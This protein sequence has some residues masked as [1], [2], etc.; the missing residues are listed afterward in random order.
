MAMSA[1]RAGAESPSANSANNSLLA[2]ELR[3]K[4]AAAEAG[5]T[6]TGMSL[7]QAQ[8]DIALRDQKLG[9]LQSDVA[10]LKA[11]IVKQNRTFSTLDAVQEKLWDGSPLT[12]RRPSSPQ[13]G[14]GTRRSGGMAT[15]AWPRLARL[16]RASPAGHQP[17]RGS[18]CC[19]Q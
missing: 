19:R 5:V 4:L 7:T 3:N 10:R 8:G 12:R 18:L 6:R 9:Q 13:S 15:A 14:G 1:S 11:L 2:Q 16:W 17:R